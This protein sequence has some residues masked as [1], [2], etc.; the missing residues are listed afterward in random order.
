M[1]WRHLGD[2]EPDQ[3]FDELSSSL[4]VEWNSKFYQIFID[5]RG[6]HSEGITLEQHALDTSAGKQLS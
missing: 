5:L 3:F 6:Q 4:N 2:R 1:L